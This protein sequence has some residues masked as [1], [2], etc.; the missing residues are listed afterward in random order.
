MKYDYSNGFC[1]TVLKVNK[2]VT[3][4]AFKTRKNGAI[5]KQ[6]SAFERTFTTFVE[7]LNV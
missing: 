7:R 4:N 6:S 3:K 2:D 5:I 1:C